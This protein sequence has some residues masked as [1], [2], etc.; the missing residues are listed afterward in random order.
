M[1]AC[2]DMRACLAL[3]ACLPAPLTSPPVPP[4]AASRGQTSLRRAG[5]FVVLGIHTTEYPEANQG[6]WCG[7]E[8]SCTRESELPLFSAWE[9]LASR[10][11]DSHPNV[12]GAGTPLHAR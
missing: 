5:L 7:W 12:V 10:Y 3:R 6:L 4:P 8:S 1:R 11:C 9:A 2:L